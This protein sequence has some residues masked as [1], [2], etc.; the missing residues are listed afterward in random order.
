M[1]VLTKNKNLKKAFASTS[2]SDASRSSRITAK[3]SSRLLEKLE[4]VGTF[5]LGG[6]QGYVLQV[7]DELVVLLDDR[8]Y[9]LQNL[10]AEKQSKAQKS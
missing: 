10:E 9:H 8:L 4:P 6:K 3:R 7:K 1:V 5:H 2:N